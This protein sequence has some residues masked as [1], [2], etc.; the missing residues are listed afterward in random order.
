[1]FFADDPIAER[2]APGSGIP[3]QLP[4][5]VWWFDPQERTLIPVISRGDV[6]IPN[7]IRVEA[8]QTKVYLTDSS[9]TDSFPLCKEE[10]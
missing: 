3:S 5:A 6:Q 4:D 2:S 8:N 7:I 1:M 9:T 10:L